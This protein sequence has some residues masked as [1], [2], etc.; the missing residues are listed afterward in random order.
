MDKNSSLSPKKDDLKT[1][2][3]T[4][5]ANGDGVITPTEFRAAFEK[6]GEIW[7]NQEILDFV[8]SVDLNA[9]GVIDYQEFLKVMK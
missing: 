3:E 4:F 9:D 2:F 7:S 6:M 8:D 5:D 1:V